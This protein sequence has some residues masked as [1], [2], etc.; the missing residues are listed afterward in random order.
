MRFYIDECLSPVLARDLNRNDEHDA[1][2]PRDRG[3]L[4]EPDHIVFARSIE[5]DRILVT[6]NSGDFRRLAATVDLHPGVITL[7][8]VAR[9][10]AARLMALAIAFLN[11][12]GVGRPQDLMIN[13]ILTVGP[14]AR[15][16]ISTWPQD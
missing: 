7:P 13:S 2:H 11:Q 6:E 15:I 8:S 3:R 14:D 5:E 1:I 10:E 9:A 12:D 4:R 16:V